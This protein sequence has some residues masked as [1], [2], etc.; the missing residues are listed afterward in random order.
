M[1]CRIVMLEWRRR[2]GSKA[3]DFKLNMELSTWGFFCS[4]ENSIKMPVREFCKGMLLG[5]EENRR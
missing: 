5:D 4:S 2:E 1:L 3:E